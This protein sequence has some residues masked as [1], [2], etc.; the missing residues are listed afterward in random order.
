M[1]LHSVNLGNV[2]FYA[3]MVL[4]ATLGLR[5]VFFGFEENKCSMSY[6]FEYP[7]FQVSAARP[8]SPRLSD[9]LVPTWPL[10]SPPRRPAGPHR[11]PHLPLVPFL[12]EGVFP[13]W[14][15]EHPR[16]PPLGTVPCPSALSQ[17]PHAVRRLYRLVQPTPSM[18][19]PSPQIQTPPPASLP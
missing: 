12:H 11:C 7:E 16:C 19:S 15:P 18:L 13:R 6:M 5:D 17:T 8:G 1:F 14:F 4:M 9:P 2:A 10:P 3:F